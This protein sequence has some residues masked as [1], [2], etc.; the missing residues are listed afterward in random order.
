MNAEGAYLFRHALL[1][2]AAYQL[3]L[4]GDRALLHGLAF[5]V[6]ETIFGGRAPE[7]P[8][9]DEAG[10]AP[11]RPHATDSIAFELAE[12]VR[13]ARSAPGASANQEL[14]ATEKLYWR[15]AASH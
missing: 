15:R 2:D 7:P 8:P 5:S 3:Q 13:L 1:R 11:M 6:M 14:L 10:P 4:P 9:L 12:Q